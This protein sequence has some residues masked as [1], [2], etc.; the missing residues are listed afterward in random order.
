MLNIR[1]SQSKL[2]KK[3]QVEVT[4]ERKRDVDLYYSRKRATKGDLCILYEVHSSPPNCISHTEINSQ[5]DLPRNRAHH[6]N[7]LA[8]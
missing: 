8:S 1:M 6:L 2:I 4:Y 7:Y 5:V 3:N